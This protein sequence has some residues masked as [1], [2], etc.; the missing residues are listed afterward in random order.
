VKELS[1]RRLAE[2]LD[3][4]EHGLT[5]EQILS[6]FPDQKETLRP[7]LETAIRLSKLATLPT[8]GAKHQ[9]GQAMLRAAADMQ[10]ARAMSPPLWIGLKRL[11]MPVT[12]FAV[13]LLLIGATLLIASA[14]ALPGYGLYGAK[15]FVEEIRLSSASDDAARSALHAAFNQERIR[16]VEALLRSGLDA[17]V[18]FQGPIG[19]IGQDRWA[20]A[21]ILVGVSDETIIEGRPQRAAVAQVHG[22]T[23]DG[24]L[25]AIRLV[26]ETEEE[27]LPEPLPEASS[28]ATPTATAPA[29]PTASSTATSS[30]VSTSTPT[31]HDDDANETENGGDEN[32]NDDGGNQNED[33]ENENEGDENSNEEDEGNVNDNG[34]DDGNENEDDDSNENDDDDASDNEDDD[35]NENEDEDEDDT[36]ED[37]EA[38]ENEEDGSENEAEENENDSSG[39]G[40]GNENDNENNDNEDNDNK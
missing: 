35:G 25:A 16:E 9:S 34:S 21:D 14:S 26:V 10:P 8:L 30:P 4:L 5:V 19:E 13:V 23:H 18:R 17:E 20:V 7:F 38:N 31:P 3:L 6:R 15:Q 32:E 24:R 1:E 29:T 11:L 28:T 40:N 39:S 27:P 36:N 37:E 12:S 33:A 2:C 22:R